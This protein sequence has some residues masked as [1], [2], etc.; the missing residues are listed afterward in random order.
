MKEKRGK[1]KWETLKRGIKRSA[2]LIALAC[3]PK[4]L[5]EK[6]LA[7]SVQ[8][9]RVPVGTAELKGTI[10]EGKALLIRWWGSVES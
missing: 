1:E 3:T 8:S 2:Y 4:P 9:S 7:V 5:P 10:E 6:L